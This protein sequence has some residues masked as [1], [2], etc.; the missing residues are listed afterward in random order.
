[1]LLNPAGASPNPKSILRLDEIRV[2]PFGGGGAN[3]LI[4]VTPSLAYHRK[5]RKDFKNPFSAA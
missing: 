4:L 3:C 1:M 5:G 2:T